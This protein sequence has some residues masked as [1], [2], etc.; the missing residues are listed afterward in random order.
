MKIKY[1]LFYV[2]TYLLNLPC[3]IIHELCHWLFLLPLSMIG[4]VSMPTIKMDRLASYSINGDE[5]ST[6]SFKMS[7]CY[8]NYFDIDWINRLCSIMPA[9][10]TIA[11]FIVSPFYLYP[12]YLSQINTL[13]MSVGDINKMMGIYPPA[14]VDT[15]TDCA[16]TGE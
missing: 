10:G 13:W 16:C 12:Y 2:E 5:S 7:V 3:Y 8:K 9:L 1:L 14:P 11:L 15:C 4:L 6:W